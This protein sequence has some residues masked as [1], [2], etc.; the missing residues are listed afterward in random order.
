MAPQTLWFHLTFPNIW[1]RFCGQGVLSLVSSAAP[2][3]ASGSLQS[4]A[5]VSEANSKR[6]WEVLIWKLIKAYPAH[7][8]VLEGTRGKVAKMPFSLGPSA[9]WYNLVVPWSKWTSDQFSSVSQSCLTLC[10][11]MNRNTPGLPVHHQLLEFTQILPK[12]SEKYTFLDLLR[13]E[14]SGCPRKEQRAY[15]FLPLPWYQ[16]GDHWQVRSVPP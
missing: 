4:A 11:P 5:N 9:G 1:P 7:T 8:P 16:V 12:T 13:L 14:R 15:V 6:S 2:F 3:S 10:D